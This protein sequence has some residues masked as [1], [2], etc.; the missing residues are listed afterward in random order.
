MAKRATGRNG[1]DGYDRSKDAAWEGR[2]AR[3]AVN[4]RPVNW[5][6]PVIAGDGCW[7]GE[8]F[9]HDWPGKADGAPH[10]REQAAS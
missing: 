5:G 1:L 8:P 7:C 2:Q 3:A 4:G 6:E 9:G 10:P